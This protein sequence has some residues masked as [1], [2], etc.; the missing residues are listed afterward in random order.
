M[1]ELNEV[2]SSFYTPN[3]NNFIPLLL[4]G[5]DKFDGKKSHNILIGT[6]KFIKS[7]LRWTVCAT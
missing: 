1:N 4:Y 3:G 6:I 7:S 2:D 5:S